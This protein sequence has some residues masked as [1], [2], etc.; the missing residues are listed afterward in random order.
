MLLCILHGGLLQSASSR[1]PDFSA[2]RFVLERLVN[3]RQEVL[4]GGGTHNLVHFA[5]LDANRAVTGFLNSSASS[6]LERTIGTTISDDKTEPAHTFSVG[7]GRFA[8]FHE[9]GA[10]HLVLREY[11][12]GSTEKFVDRDI[13]VEGLQ[14]PAYG[15]HPVVLSIEHG[16][17]FKC[18]SAQAGISKTLQVTSPHV[19]T[20]KHMPP[21]GSSAGG[22]S[23]GCLCRDCVQYYSPVPSCPPGGLPPVSS[24]NSSSF[25]QK[26]NS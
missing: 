6:Q 17:I 8:L 2:L 13:L 23:I 1:T 14:D 12:R 25:F 11:G 4:G 15:I 18:W 7:K 22:H 26:S 19:A 5:C 10:R 16:A 21:E 3:P 20:I 9:S 24:S